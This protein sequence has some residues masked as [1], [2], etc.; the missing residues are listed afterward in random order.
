MSS[1]A[2]SYYGADTIPSAEDT[3]DTFAH[4]SL[5]TDAEIKWLVG[6]VA[7]ND[8][9]GATVKGI[10]G[11]LRLVYKAEDFFSIPRVLASSLVELPSRGL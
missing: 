5:T 9:I 10:G 8:L 4:G 6:P 11:Y 2:F 1:Y 7:S 3:I